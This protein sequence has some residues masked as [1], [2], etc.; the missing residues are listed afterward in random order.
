MCFK[1]LWINITNYLEKKAIL[2][3]TKSHKTKLCFSVM[4]KGEILS[5]YDCAWLCS[6]QKKLVY[7][8]FVQ[9]VP[10]DAQAMPNWKVWIEKIEM[11]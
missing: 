2:A 4:T 5:S 6:Q 11:E 3:V 9:T 10:F 8:N 1:L 7:S